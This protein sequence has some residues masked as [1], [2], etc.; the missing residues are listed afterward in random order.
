M[1][2]PDTDD[3]RGMLGRGL[4]FPFA[5]DARAGIALVSG[6]DD[7]DQ[8]IRIIL[9]TAPGERAMRPE[10][11]CGVHEF[12]FEVIDPPAIGRME[13]EIRAS[14]HRWEPR[15]EVDEIRFD[16]HP[17]TTDVLLIEIDYK[18]RESATIRN[19]VYPFYLVPAEG[20]GA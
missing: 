17:D 11:G 16:T 20:S 18:L 5:T 19:L 4:A 9:S 10:F 8:A 2:P 7:V 3:V 12:V 6:E 1:T 14:L 15:I 13:R